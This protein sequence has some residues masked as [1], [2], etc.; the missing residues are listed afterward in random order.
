MLYKCKIINPLGKIQVLKIEGFSQNEVIE[1]L[2]KDNYSI[3][4]VQKQKE[5]QIS[6]NYLI[7]IGATNKLKSKELAVFCKQLYSM[8]KSKLT[9]LS[10]IEILSLQ[11]ENKKLQNIIG[12]IYKELLTGST[13]S[14]SLNN[15]KDLF[16][17]IFISMASSGE[18]SG[19]LES[20]MGRLSDHYEREYKVENKIRSAMT[21][22]IILSIV[23]TSIVIFLLIK[24][25]PTFVG[26]YESS[27]IPL[28]VATSFLLLLSQFIKNSWYIFIL[29]III[30]FLLILKLKKTK[31]FKLKTDYYK[32]K[33]PIY[34]NM[35][36]KVVASRFTRALS[37]LLINGIPL[38]GALDTVSKVTGNAYIEYLILEI[39]EEVR[40][41]VLLSEAVKNKEIFPVMVYSMIKI[42]EDTGLI[43]ELLDKTAIYY[44]EEVESA[45]QK[46]VN[47][48]EPLMIVIMSALI[49]FIVL[50]MISPMFDMI[51]MAQ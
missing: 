22:P 31:I 49:G 27:N 4:N 10:C 11:I 18:I 30:L 29:I 41:G 19:N 40:N 17:D 14:E 5:N 24:V 16:P 3:I 35:V 25:M 39:K 36:I 6:F 32:L 20:V 45:V 28:P 8:L 7:T 15:H 47:L 2:K 38:L 48:I 50:A 42:G 1:I 51:K 34:K 23:A 46:F 21:Y 37:T 44:D 13:F 33:I 43:E 26:I 9:I 12:Q